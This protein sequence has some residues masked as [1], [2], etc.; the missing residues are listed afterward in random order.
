MVFTPFTRVRYFLVVYEWSLY[1]L[2][3]FVTF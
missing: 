3:M 1:D 2:H